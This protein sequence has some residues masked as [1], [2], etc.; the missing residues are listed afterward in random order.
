MI[1]EIEDRHERLNSSG[2]KGQSIAGYFDETPGLDMEIKT[3]VGFAVTEVNNITPGTTTSGSMN[4]TTPSTNGH[5]PHLQSRSQTW[6]SNMTTGT[7]ATQTSQ[8]SYHQGQS[9]VG[10]QQQQ[11]DIITPAPSNQMPEQPQAYWAG[12]AEG[13]YTVFYTTAPSEDIN[14][15]P[16]T[17]VQPQAAPVSSVGYNVSTTPSTNAGSNLPGQSQ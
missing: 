8:H 15:V 1:D 3:G 4:G 13:G 11:D 5:P 6:A 16:S 9:V 10:Q 7:T 2:G 12:T 17:Q 14:T